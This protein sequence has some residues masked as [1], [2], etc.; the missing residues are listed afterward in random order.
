VTSSPSAATEEGHRGDVA[1]EGQRRACELEPA[2]VRAPG[3][4]G[5][6]GHG[7]EASDDA[8]EEGGEV[9]HAPL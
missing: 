4:D 3:D 5:G 8:D 2:E 1:D 7:P 9:E 6:R